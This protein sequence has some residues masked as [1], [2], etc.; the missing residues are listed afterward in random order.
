VTAGT[1]RAAI[2]EMGRS[3]FERGLTPGRTGNLSVRTDRGFLA[4]PTGTS[5]GRL[6]AEGLSELDAA[7]QRTAG[8]V[9]TKEIDLHAAMYTLVPDA[10]AVVHLHS[11]YAVA[12]ACLERD[13]A[14]PPLRALTPY[15]LMRVGAV[16]WIPYHP[17]G[18]PALAADLR[19]F[20]QGRHAAMLANHGP[21]VA[22]P[23]LDAAADA[24]E[25]L[26]ATARLE[27]ILGDRPV[28]VLEATDDPVSPARG[29]ATTL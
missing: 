2:V 7:W 28:R 20:A 21:I 25:E 15:F 1:D 19:R 17:P 14:R 26:E 9:P 27:L 11:P 18:D 3:L 29:R 23:D 22:G 24:I 6:D 4:T 5:L 13:P 8:P 16:A 10:G 12:I